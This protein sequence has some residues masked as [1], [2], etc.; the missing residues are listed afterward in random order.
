M[1][2]QP[3]PCVEYRTD[4]LSV[5]QRKTN[6]IAYHRT[7]ICAFANKDLPNRAGDDT[8]IHPYALALD[9][10]NIKLQAL[11][12]IKIAAAADL[13]QTS[14]TRHNFKPLGMPQPVGFWRKR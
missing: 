5:L 4:G 11:I 3:S 12:E 1:N 8:N 13:P 14:D 7:L 2:Y 9:I 6:A 10:C